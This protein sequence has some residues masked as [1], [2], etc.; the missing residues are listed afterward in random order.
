MS[1]TVRNDNDQAS[2][3]TS[4][5][6]DEVSLTDSDEEGEPITLV[7]SS[8]GERLDKWLAGQMPERSRAEIQR[9][10]AAGLVCV[11]GA[12]QK[13][14]YRVMP[15]DPVTVVVPAPEEYR[16]EPEP[17]PL[18]IL[19]ED[20]DL[21]VV[22]KPAGMVVHPAAGHWHGTLVNAV[23]HHCPSLEGVG[24]VHRP[25]IVHRL[26]K[27]TSGVI[28]VAKNDRAHRSLQAQFKARQ[29]EKTYLALVHGV[30]SP[31]GGMVE[32]AISRD[33]RH[34]ERMAVVPDGMGRPA[35]TRFE[36]LRAFGKV[37]LVACHPLTGRTHQVRVHLAYL[38]HPIVADTLYAGRRNP[39]APDALAPSGAQGCGLKGKSQVACPRQFLHAERIRFRLPSTGEAV[40]FTAPLPADLQ[41]VLEAL[42]A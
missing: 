23:L 9:W 22:D 35:V 15:G 42:E 31:G 4:E 8:G 39:R 18:T 36:V 25:G 33:R 7:P 13:P 20:G 34:R 29:V 27:D 16:V 14:S 11:G 12:T 32:A 21:L 6:R 1:E 19:Y 30:V 5:T 41:A 26:D 40:E 28:L 24:G 3:R 17:I 37:T 10:I 2:S 38:G